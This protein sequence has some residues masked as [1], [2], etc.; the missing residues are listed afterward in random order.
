M[1]D[2]VKV[3]SAPNE[4]FALPMEGVPTDSDIPMLIHRGAGFDIR[5]LLSAGPRDVLL[6]EPALVEACRLLKDTTGL[7]SWAT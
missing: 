5:D 7:E 1:G 6:P 4:T 3:G 2:W